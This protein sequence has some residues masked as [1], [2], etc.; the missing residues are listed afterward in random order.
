MRC[1]AGLSATQRRRERAPQQGVCQC[2]RAPRPPKAP[3]CSSGQAT[4][5]GVPGRI[6]WRHPGHRYALV[7][8]SPL[9]ARTRQAPSACSSSRP[10]PCSRRD[11]RSSV[12]SGSRP[13]PCR[14]PGPP[15][16]GRRP[17]P[18]HGPVPPAR[19]G[20][21][22]RGMSPSVGGAG[23]T[24]RGGRPIV[25]GSRQ[26]ERRISRNVAGREEQVPRYDVRCRACGTTF[27]VTRSMT[28]AD[29]PAPC[30]QGHD[31]TVRLLPTVGLT[32]RATGRTT[33]P[34]VGAPGTATSGCCGGGCCG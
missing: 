13:A 30:P 32:G 11:A 5:C 31:D 33:A 14:C 21:L 2:R 28:R 29:E 25:T 16:A 23:H 8:A 7:V 4:T 9:T 26:Q 24:G 34:V 12:S 3:S 17:P 22:L 18:R 19:R 6:C 27:E 10:P 15:P 20:R 1:R